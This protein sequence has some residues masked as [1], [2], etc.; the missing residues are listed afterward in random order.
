M[1][2]NH[3]ICFAAMIRL[4]SSHILS[5]HSEAYLVSTSGSDLSRFAHSATVRLNSIALS[6]YMSCWDLVLG[7]NDVRDYSDGV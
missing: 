2:P 7:T 6:N 4:Y 5:C 1:V 3:A